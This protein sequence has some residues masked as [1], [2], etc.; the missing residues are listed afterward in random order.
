LGI[1]EQ[2]RTGEWREAFCKNQAIQAANFG[3]R[4]DRVFND[5]WVSINGIKYYTQEGLIKPLDRLL[6][7][8]WLEHFSPAALRDAQ[9]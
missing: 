7:E 4:L 9:A 2:R 5:R 1:L 3:F 6:E 8:K